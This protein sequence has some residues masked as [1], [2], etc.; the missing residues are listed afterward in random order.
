MVR[1]VIVLD[2]HALV[3]WTQQSELLGNEAAEA[4]AQSDRILVPAIC[5]WETALLVRTGRLSLKRGQPVDEW[6]SEVLAIPRVIA[7]PLTPTLALSADA[8]QM[9]PDPADRFI[10]A[11][12]IEQRAS[13]VTKDELLRSLSWLKTVW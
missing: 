12:A 9:H 6:A 5:F 1:D 2:T 7:V 4:I 13:L 3:W 11:T 10:V 8:L